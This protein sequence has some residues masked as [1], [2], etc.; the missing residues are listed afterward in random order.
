MDV[1]LSGPLRLWRG[2]GRLPWGHASALAGGIIASFGFAPYAFRPALWAGLVLFFCTLHSGTTATAAKRGGLFGLGYFG[3]GVYWVY[4][5]LYN[6][7]STPLWLAIALAALLVLYLSL[8]PMLAASMAACLLPKGVKRLTGAAV[9]LAAA[10]WLR[11]TLLTG[12]P[13][14]LI[15]QGSLDSPW[16][17]YLPL[18]GVHGAGLMLLLAAGW[19]AAWLRRPFSMRAVWL[20]AVMVIVAG[21]EFLRPVAWSMWSTPFGESIEVAMVQPNLNQDARWRAKKRGV[22]K[23]TYWHLTQ[24][25][26]ETPLI[27]WPEAAIPQ[28]YSEIE[29]FYKNIQDEVLG[30]DTTLL[31]GVFYR[32]GDQSGPHNGLMNIRTGQRYGK[33]RLVPF[34]EYSPLE[35]WLG[36]LYRKIHFR[37]RA[38]QPAEGRPLLQVRG[39]PVGITICYESVYPS[40]P[41]LSFPEAAYLVNVSNDA[42]FGATRAPWQHLES[43]RVRAAETAREL[44]RVASTGVTAI[45]GADGTLRATAPQFAT[46]ILEGEVQPREGVTPYVRFGEW[47][48]AALSLLVLTFCFYQREKRVG[49]DF[50]RRFR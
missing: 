29:D 1:N 16:A 15:G 7:A 13:W 45:I 30:D 37:M 8:Y 41:R 25:V 14:V 32:E 26:E 24:Q 20:G 50:P 18:L 12:F 48:F 27:I 43:S 39:S 5:S 10:E 11:G 17:S 40:I 44:L 28:Y 47:L 9:L 3:F 2:L 38:L 6:Y 36:P 42:W 49:L 23:E 33:R 21:G 31:A 4:Y 35:D 34:G 19:T 22:I 46:A